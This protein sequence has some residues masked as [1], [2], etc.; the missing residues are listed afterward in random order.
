LLKKNSQWRYTEKTLKERFD[1]SEHREDFHRGSP[2]R[3]TRREKE[4][5]ERDWVGEEQGR[6]NVKN[7]K[8]MATVKCS[9]PGIIWT[10]S[11]W[12]LSSSGISHIRS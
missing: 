12:I 8:R 10:L 6:D 1:S 3:K 2:S 7:N 11:P 4:K 9:L 5:R